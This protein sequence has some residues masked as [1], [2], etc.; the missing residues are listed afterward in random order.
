MS[1]AYSRPC[2]FVLFR[3]LKAGTD[4]LRSGRLQRAH[5]AVRDGEKDKIQRT[6]YGVIGGICAL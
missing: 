6:A 1:G 2:V 5:G 3:I 4:L